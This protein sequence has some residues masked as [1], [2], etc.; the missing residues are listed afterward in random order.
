[1]NKSPL[2]YLNK[3]PLP[4]LAVDKEHTITWISHYFLEHYNLKARDLIGKNS[5]SIFKIRSNNQIIPLSSLS[6]FSQILEVNLLKISSLGWFKIQRIQMKSRDFH[7]L[8]LFTDVS[9]YINDIQERVNSELNYHTIFQNAPYSNVLLSLDGIVIDCNQKTADIFELQV[10]EMIGISYP[11]LIHISKENKNFYE[12]LANQISS[13]VESTSFP[14]EID[15]LKGNHKILEIF[16]S[17]IRKNNIPYSIHLIIHDLTEEKKTEQKLSESITVFAAFMENFNGI[18][19]IKSPEGKYIYLNKTMQKMINKNSGKNLSYEEC[20]GKT[21]FD[22]FLETDAKIFRKND[23][24]VLN[25]QTAVQITETV[26]INGILRTWLVNKFSIANKGESPWAVAGMGV[27]ISDQKE[28]EDLLKI[29]RDFGISLNEVT[30]QDDLF[31]LCMESALKV[32][33]IDLIGVYLSNNITHSFELK[34]HVGG[35]PEF[36][37]KMRIHQF[38]NG[39]EGILEKKEPIYR[40]FKYIKATA[41]DP[42]TKEG[43]KSYCV[44]P[45]IVKNQSMGVFNVASRNYETISNQTGNTLELISSQ[46]GTTLEKIWAQE[47]IKLDENRLEALLELTQMKYESEDEIYNFAL[48]KGVQLTKSSHGFIAHVD[49]KDHYISQMR[50]WSIHA[51]NM[52]PIHELT[53]KNSTVIDKGVWGEIIRTNKPVFINNMNEFGKDRKLFPSNPREIFRFIAVPIFVRDQLFAVAGLWNKKENYEDSDVHQVTLL[54]EAVVTL[55]RKKQDEAQQEVYRRELERN[56]EEIKLNERRL[57]TLLKLNQMTEE[58]EDQIYNFVLM[59]GVGITRS[60]SGFISLV[61]SEGKMKSMRIWSTNSS[62]PPKVLEVPEHYQDLNKGVWIEVIH[63]KKPRIINDT[64]K[65]VI[66][67]KFLPPD[68]PIHRYILIPVVIRNRIYAVVAMGNKKEDYIDSDVKQIQL[69]IDAVTTIMQKKQ[70]EEQ[71]EF[72]RKEIEKSEKINALGILAGGIAHDFNNILTAILGNISLAEMSDKDESRRRLNEAKKAIIRSKELTQ[73][74]LTFSKGGTPIKK[75]SSITTLL[76]ETSNFAIRGSNVKIAYDIP[77]DL[78]AA[79]IDEGQISQVINNLV[80]NSIQAMPNG[81][82]LYIQANNKIIHQDSKLPLVPGN[83]I[84]I[85]VQDEGVGIPEKFLDQIFDPYFT[86]KEKGSGLGLATSYAIISKHR[87]HITVKSK[88]GIGSS[89][90][91]FIPAI[92]DKQP[93]E[94]KKM[95]ED[96]IYGTGKILLMD[97]EEIIRKVAKRM[98]EKLGYTVATTID[99][100]ETIELYKSALVMGEPY[101]VVVLDLTIPGGM[102]GKETVKELKTLHPELKAI[103]SSGYSV[104][105]IMSE[106]KKFGFAGIIAKPWKFEE[107]SK[108][109]HSVLNDKYDPSN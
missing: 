57:E 6:K 48:E 37:E 38:R 42:I 36:V 99:G 25:T 102:G 74:L 3:L 16:P 56:I 55:I 58:P 33:E 71:R 43:I 86:T 13:G 88:V 107:F 46:L 109:I 24:Q 31:A 11:E 10:D 19:F 4:I 20:L 84:A 60:E 75:L 41:I 14:T 23:L 62:N 79:E 49:P 103:V 65:S 9:E 1:M 32:P 91:V 100:E 108:V 82:T 28:S 15:T 85:T 95:D 80:L 81:G 105:P 98:L 106:Y 61:N 34:Y 21:D 27:D 104:D 40:D 87:G 97:D 26:R 78:W 44:I 63:D 29:Q 66:A 7:E 8:I 90:S 45:I 47:K 69:L 59:E 93:E 94:M 73:Q 39:D 18:A 5:N 96:L 50:I 12:D 52:P 101:D 17:L 70:D 35:S 92:S 68:P 83:Y 64:K 76:R 30:E 51:K 72:Y 54:I 67:Q 22:L 77:K 89:F 53:D 2:D